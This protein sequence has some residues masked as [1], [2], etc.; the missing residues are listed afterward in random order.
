MILVSDLISSIIYRDTRANLYQLEL[1]VSWESRPEGHGGG[2]CKYFLVRESK[3]AVKETRRRL[4]GGRGG[5][6]TSTAVTRRVVAILF[7]RFTVVSS[8]QLKHLCRM[9]LRS[10]Y[11][12]RQND[13][14]MIV[15][16]TCW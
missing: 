5:F 7:V 15:T 10:E 6:I 1:I 8:E 12:V 16:A 2:P 3:G 14:E 13:V 9:K 11:A 4:G